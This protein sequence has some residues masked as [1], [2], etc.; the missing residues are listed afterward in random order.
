MP[1]GYV[2]ATRC[3]IPSVAH[4]RAN[5]TGGRHVTPTKITRGG[6]SCPILRTTSG[7]RPPSM[8]AWCIITG[9]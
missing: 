5:C 9:R 6:R 4:D 3:Q 2:L 8:I 7:C 1:G